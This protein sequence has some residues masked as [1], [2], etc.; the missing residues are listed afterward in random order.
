M[1]STPFWLSILA[2]SRV[3]QSC[4]LVSRFQS[5]KYTNDAFAVMLG[6]APHRGRLQRSQLNLRGRFASKGKGGK[7]ERKEGVKDDRNKFLANALG[8]G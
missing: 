2:L 8:V 1:Q 3:F 5:P 7:R 4:S 6:C